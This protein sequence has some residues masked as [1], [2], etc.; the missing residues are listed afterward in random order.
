MS[1]RYVYLDE[2]KRAGY[3]MAA[4]AVADPAAVRTVIRG[5]VQPGN[6]R[7]HMVD[8]RPR[9]RPR[10]VSALVETEIEVTIYDAVRNYRTDREARSAC[11]AVLVED[12]AIT[13][14][15][16]LLVIEQD[17]SLVRFDRHEL[18]RLARAA[19]I[20][21]ILEYRHQRAHDEALLALPD[22]A[23]W[24]WVRSGEWRRRIGPILTNVRQIR[25]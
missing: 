17:D 25:P 21:D 10:I 13:G 24:C 20:T 7:L 4:V 2:T 12:L 5:L 22:L 8:E 15:K 3:V 19:G 11:L 23:A 14:A 6:R 1:T 18:Y 16:T 9:H